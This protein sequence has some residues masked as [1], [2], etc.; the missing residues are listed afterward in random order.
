MFVRLN[1]GLRYPQ[2]GAGTFPLRGYSLLK[3]MYYAYKNGCVSFDTSPAYGNERWIGIG[4]KMLKLLG[5]KRIY[6]TTKLS[7][8]GQ[9]S[10]DVRAEFN[11]SLKRL[12]VTYIDLYLMHWPN[13]ETYVEA[14]LEMERIYKE[15]HVGA[16]GVCNFHEH[17]LDKILE[18]AAVVPAV[19]QV[20]L[21][22]L[23]T[24]NK[25]R[26][27]CS[28]KGIQVQSYSPVARMD[29]KLIG[30]E[31]LLL[32]ANRHHKS[33]PQ[34]ILKWNI[35][36]GLRVIPKSASSFKIKEN[37]SLNDFVLTDVELK[38][39]DSLNANY[40]VRYDPDNADFSKL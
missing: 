25:L 27:Y 24:Q 10:G 18:V 14:W 23:L 22:P 29:K 3:A 26:E 39:I 12:G 30:N 36:S 5:A 15:G 38:A 9:R 13:P 8:S 28:G 21:H 6:V 11:S 37:F 34:I 33:V 19:N 4:I 17:H 7:N 1:N 40:R 16:I 35:Q 20:E 32:I 2:I 31:A